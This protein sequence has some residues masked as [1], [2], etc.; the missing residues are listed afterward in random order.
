[1]PLAWSTML[2]LPKQQLFLL[3]KEQTAVRL[4]NSTITHVI[5]DGAVNP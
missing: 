4:R 3:Y 5:S 2:L 1:M